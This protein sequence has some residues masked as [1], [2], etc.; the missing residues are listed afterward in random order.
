LLGGLDGDGAQ[1][2]QIDMIGLGARRDDRLD[3]GNAEFG[4]FFDH[5]IGFL[6]L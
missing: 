3:N 6:A 2:V 5:Q 1:A 4:G